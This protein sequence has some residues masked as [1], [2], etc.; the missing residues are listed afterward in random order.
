MTSRI[1]R[2]IL[3]SAGLASLAILLQVEAAQAYVGPGLGAGAIAVVLGIV[4]SV[5]LALFAVLW[6]PLKRL[7]RKNR[8]PGVPGGGAKN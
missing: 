3:C 6:Y 7:L 2:T 8:T 5:F 1:A 4:G